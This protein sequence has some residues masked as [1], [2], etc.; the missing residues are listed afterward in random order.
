MS[1]Y[2]DN[3]RDFICLVEHFS[4]VYSNALENVQ[5][6]AEADARLNIIKW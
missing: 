1:M 5:S 3:F 2:S 4:A 6:P